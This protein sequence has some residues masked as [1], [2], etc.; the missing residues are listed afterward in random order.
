MVSSRLPATH[1]QSWHFKPLSAVRWR[2]MMNV[3]VRGLCKTQNKRP[4]KKNQWTVSENAEIWLMRRDVRSIWGNQQTNERTKMR[5]GKKKIKTDADQAYIKVECREIWVYI[6]KM[7][8]IFVM[9]H[10]I[11]ILFPSIFRSTFPK[12]RAEMR[13]VFPFSIILYGSVFFFFLSSS[14]VV[15]IVVRLLLLWW[16]DMIF[17]LHVPSLISKMFCKREKY[18]ELRNDERRIKSAH[19]WSG[20]E[21]RVEG[22]SKAIFYVKMTIKYDLKRRRRC[23]LLVMN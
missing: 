21:R 2:G 22:S 8:V 4:R 17:Y 19:E 10:Y 9:C 18:M 16:F 7:Q 1:E 3:Y 23:F 15:V 12:N 20:D 14:Q 6:I 13:Q 5:E 11:I